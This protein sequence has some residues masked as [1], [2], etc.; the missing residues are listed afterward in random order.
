MQGT[1]YS[2]PINAIMKTISVRVLLLM[3]L[4]LWA[5]PSVKAQEA[6]MAVPPVVLDGIGFT[7]PVSVVGDTLSMEAYSVKG[8]SEAIPLTFDE[9]DGWIADGVVVNGRDFQDVVL[10]RS[11]Q[12]VVRQATRSIPGW[13]SIVPPILAIVVALIFKRVIPALFLGLWVGAVTVA[14]FT[15]QGLFMGL[16]NTFEVYV[17]KVFIDPDHA[18]IILFSCMIGGMVGIIS[19]NGG[20]Q[21]VVNLIVKWATDPKKGQIATG[22]LGLSIF[23]DDYANSLVVGNTMRPVTDRLR[24][25]REKLAYIVDSTAAPVACLALVT[26]WIGYEVGMIGTAVDKIDGLEGSAYAFFLSSIPYSFYPLLAIFFVFLV[27]FSRRDF[28]PMYKAEVRARTLNQVISPEAQIDEE[29]A[30]SKE[31][32]PVEG[33]PHRAINAIIPVLVLVIG[34][35]VGLY[36]TGDGE[37]M[38]DII[39]SSDS[40]KSL[41]WAS[42]LGVVVAGV[43][44]SAQ[45]I[46]TISEVVESWYAGLKGMLFAMIILIM[47][48]ALSAITDDLHTASFLVSVLGDALHPGVVPTIV[49]LLAAATA[50]STG[51]S[52]GTMG[53]LMPLVIPLT[54]AVMAGAGMVAAHD[55]HILYSSI[56]AVLAGAVWGDHC[57][58][59]SD[60]TILSSMAS[61]CDHIDHV[62]TQLPYALLVGGV[63]IF[64]GTLPVGFG[65]PWWASLALGATMLVVVLRYFG[66]IADNE[67]VIVQS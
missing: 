38:K 11:G 28:G 27:S 65:F 43:M 15:F 62:R 23:F 12:E 21:G 26:T 6:T 3:G 14:S 66:K 45:R 34:V 57:S 19:K 35:L 50:F 55:Y 48:W 61:G 30:E 52:W 4:L 47:A 59:I 29:A 16:L 7:V 20:M 54:W 67:A 49:F 9:D 44:S 31:T 40:F 41:M 25:S 17:L 24:I 5:A 58:P 22:A 32:R 33:K 2:E 42:L 56:S 13:L 53:I 8:S 60:T 18:A 37:S 10:L 36:V 51:S 64:G 39:G 63:A 1:A 46:L